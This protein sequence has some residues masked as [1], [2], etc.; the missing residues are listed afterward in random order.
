LSFL[1]WGPCANH[2]NYRDTHAKGL[3]IISL[4]NMTNQLKLMNKD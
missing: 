4:V 3:L 1:H 2:I